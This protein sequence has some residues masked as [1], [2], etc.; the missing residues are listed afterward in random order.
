MSWKRVFDQLEDI[1]ILLD[2]QGRILHTNRVME[3]W[4]GIKGPSLRGKP[5]A[6][7][8]GGFSSPG[9]FLR[10]FREEGTL[11]YFV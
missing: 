4:T 10:F 5:L 1:I 6:E 2:E 8:S 3:S 7:L 9:E 11:P